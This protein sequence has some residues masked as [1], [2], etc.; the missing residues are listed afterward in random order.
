VIFGNGSVE[1]FLTAS[2]IGVAVNRRNTQAILLQKVIY[3]DRRCG[4]CRRVVAIVPLTA[5]TTSVWARGRLS[6]NNERHTE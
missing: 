5:I 3:V 1:Q 2:S 6:N 4:N